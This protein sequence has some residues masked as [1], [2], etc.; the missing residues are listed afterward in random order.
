MLLFFCWGGGGVAVWIAVSV[1]C[2][3]SILLAYIPGRCLQ[4]RT[5][6]FLK[7]RARAEIFMNSGKKDAKNKHYVNSLPCYR[8]SRFFH[9]ANN[10][11]TRVA[12]T[13]IT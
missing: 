9:I 10:L 8:L 1:V 11:R 3:Y 2:T 5:Q 7:R 13:K 12:K 4:G 6:D